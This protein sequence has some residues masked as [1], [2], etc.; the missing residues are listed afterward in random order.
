M[1]EQTH[2]APRPWY[3][4]FWAWFVFT[5]LIVVVVACAFTVSIAFK[6]KDSVVKDDYY[7][8]G[9]MINSEFKS[10]LVAKQLGIVASQVFDG[11]SNLISST[12]N[13]SDWP[14]DEL[15]MLS[16]SHPFEEGRD[17]Y[18]TLKQADDLLW[19]ATAPENFEG[20]WYVKLAAIDD[21]GAETWRLQGEIQLPSDAP[22]ILN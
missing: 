19:R 1:I 6:Y 7:K 4:E 20:R 9:K 14:G 21:T 5:P 3:K 11:G 13:E 18:I 2:E 15:L 12:L 17:Y 22:F 10:D 8:I 16:L